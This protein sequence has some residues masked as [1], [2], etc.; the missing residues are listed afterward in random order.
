MGWTAVSKTD[1]FHIS[2]AQFYGGRGKNSLIP[3][4]FDITSLHSIL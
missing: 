4:L 3:E 1:I 2:W